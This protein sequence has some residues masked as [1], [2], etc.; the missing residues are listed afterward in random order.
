P[1]RI[2]AVPLRKDV[3]S[4]LAARNDAENEKSERDPSKSEREPSSERPEREALAGRKGDE[5]KPD[6]KER[7]A[8]AERKP[9]ANV[10]I[11]LEGFETRSVVLPT[12]SGSYPDIERSEERRVG[13]ECRSRW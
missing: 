3:K 7:E 5:K 9:P 1:T 12:K 13:K 10:D 4:P 6:E 8:S 11:D 2:V